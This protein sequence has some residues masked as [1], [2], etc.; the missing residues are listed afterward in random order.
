[1]SLALLSLLTLSMPTDYV[2]AISKEI[3]NSMHRKLLLMISSLKGDLIR[4]NQLNRQEDTHIWIDKKTMRLKR[5]ILCLPA[6][7]SWVRWD[8]SIYNL[9]QNL[10][11]Y[12]KK[13]KS[14]RSKGNPKGLHLSWESSEQLLLDFELM[15]NLLYVL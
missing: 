3:N 1:M 8:N 5:K 6:E 7:I 14:L 10:E 13:F 9:D 15:I 2:E 4:R 12:L 11:C